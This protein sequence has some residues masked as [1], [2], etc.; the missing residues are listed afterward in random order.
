MNSLT[1]GINFITGRCVAATASDRDTPE[2]PP[3][4]GRLFMALAAT[5]FETDENPEEADALRWLETLPPPEIYV[6]PAAKRS[7]VK[8]YVPTNDKLTANTSILQSVPGITRS[9]QERSFPTCIPNDPKV[10]YVWTGIPSED[11][12]ID[13]LRS[14]CSNVIRVGHSSSLVN[15]WLSTAGPDDSNLSEAL[16]R[17]S[18]TSTQSDE[19]V[20]VVGEGEFDRLKAACKADLINDFAELKLAIDSTKGKEQKQAKLEF[21]KKFGR[22]YAASLRCPEPTPATL[23]LWQGYRI[24]KPDNTSLDIPSSNPFDSEL[25][26]LTQIEGS[27]VGIQDALQLTNRLRD[28]VMSNCPT[29]PPPAWV[30]GHDEETGKPTS[31]PHIAFLA[32]PYVSS[33]YADGHIMGLALAIP[34]IEHVSNSQRSKMLGPLFFDADGN[35]KNIE[36]KLGRL[37]SWIVRLEERMSPPVAL[38][39]ST[40]TKPSKTWASVTPVV[41]DRF[42]RSS[43][44]S[45]RS[46]WEEEV[47]EII[48]KSC[49]RAGLPSP[50]HID[51]D[52]TSWHRGS[53]TAY[54]SSNGSQDSYMAEGDSIARSR[55][56]CGGFPLMPS[57]KGKPSRPQVHAFLRFSQ[58]VA[59]PVLL[60]AGRFQGYGLFKPIQMRG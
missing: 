5:V 54:S 50:I 41:L 59:G 43:K 42:P 11:K 13:A 44:T 8:C 55:A 27:Q 51:I 17:L 7:L 40:W 34:N 2:W 26:I 15:A 14:I 35:F 12:H 9:K 30:G 31:D 52:S 23:G 45:Q 25:L 60:G 53:P 38:Q 21:E 37:G 6:S 29:N 24:M 48:L 46:R 16:I 18:P 28:A 1:I 33:E 20:R 56:Q 58:A 47:S 19:R 3:H 22:P 4:P 57:R 36:L 32:L 39:N 10:Y 49:E